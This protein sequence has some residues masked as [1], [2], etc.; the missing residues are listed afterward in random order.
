MKAKIVLVVIIILTGFVCCHK[1]VNNSG[2]QSEGLISGPDLRA[3]A[4]C[5]GYYVQI[6]KT[7]YE[8]DSLPPNSD[9]NLQKDTFP[10]LIKLNWQI[11]QKT[12]CPLQRI[13][14]LKML[15]VVKSAK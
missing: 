8:F 3:C 5:G 1:E 15:K 13:T 9:I 12:P 7:T 4:C 14:I 10:I 2:Y 11:S 6:D